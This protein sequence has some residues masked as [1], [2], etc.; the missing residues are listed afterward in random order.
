V[1]RPQTL[2]EFPPGYLCQRGSLIDRSRLLL[3]AQRAYRDIQ[4]T[5]EIGDLNLLIDRFL[6]SETPLWWV[7]PVTNTQP[8][9]VTLPHRSSVTTPIACLWAGRATTPNQAQPQAYI[10]L[11]YVDPQHRRKGIATALLQ[12]AEAWAKQQQDQQIG[13]QVFSHNAA[14]IA[15]YQKLG[16]QTA[17]LWMTKVL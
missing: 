4:G 11:I 2:V 1:N 5:E 17:A 8:S 16:Y 13:L 10:L 9:Q 6:S 3:F 7:A 12:Q 14:A 15:L